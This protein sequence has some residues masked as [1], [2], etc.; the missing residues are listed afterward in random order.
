MSGIVGK[1]VRLEFSGFGAAGDD[2]VTEALKAEPMSLRVSDRTRTAIV[3]AMR[4]LWLVGDKGTGVSA[5]KA[6]SFAKFACMRLF[7]TMVF[8][9]RI[10][11]STVS[12]FE[13]RMLLLDDLLPLSDRACLVKGDGL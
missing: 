11:S 4:G 7:S 6:P 13:R 12:F 9:S 10:A 8:N 5:P 3:G 2:L 1:A